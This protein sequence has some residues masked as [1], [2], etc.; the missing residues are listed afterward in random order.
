[1]ALTPVLYGKFLGKFG[2]VYRREFH[3][4]GRKDHSLGS[5]ASRF[6]RHLSFLRRG[7][8]SRGVYFTRDSGFSKPL[9][10]VSSCSFDRNFGPE[11]VCVSYSSTVQNGD[12]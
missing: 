9:L 7:R 2:F 5:L 6:S 11:R 3:E 10:L 1:M 8:S 4:R 12:S